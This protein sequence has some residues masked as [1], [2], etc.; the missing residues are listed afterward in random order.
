MQRQRITFVLDDNAWAYFCASA[1]L[2]RRSLRQWFR[3]IENSRCPR[4]R[5]SA[6]WPPTAA[7]AAAQIV[8]RD[9]RSDGRSP[10][11]TA[12][13][14]SPNRRF[15]QSSNAPETCTSVGDGPISIIVPSTSSERAIVFKSSLAKMS[16]TR[17]LAIVC[18][19][20]IPFG[21]KKFARIVPAS[22]RACTSTSPSTPVTTLNSR[23]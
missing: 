10:S 14:V 21:I 20:I 17:S 22:Q 13:P 5:I 4:T 9:R 19:T 1:S 16:I 8:D 7:N 12:P 11:A 2:C 23:S 6:P 15:E 18:T 3:P